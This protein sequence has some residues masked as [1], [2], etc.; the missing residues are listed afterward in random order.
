MNA[1]IDLMARLKRPPAGTASVPLPAPGLGTGIPLPPFPQP[2]PPREAAPKP[3]AQQ[4]TIKVEVGVEILAARKAASKRTA[5]Y[6]TLTALLGIGTGFAVGVAQERAARGNLAVKS[7]GDL[8][9]EVKAAN[10]KLG[11]LGEKLQEAE[12]KLGRK[13]FPAELATALGGLTIPFEPQN[14]EKP[15]IGNMGKALRSLMRYTSAVEELN[16]DR[17]R[18]RN[19]LV[20][21]QPRAEKAW[22]EENE[23]HVGFSVI[24]R[25]ERDK[26][27]MAELVPNRD[28]FRLGADFPSE[29]TVL[30]PEMAQGQRRSVE[31]KVKRWVRGDLT[32]GDPIAVPVTPQT[33]AF[34][35]DKVV[36][37]LRLGIEELLGVLRGKNMGTHLET[38]GL[39][40][41]GA[42]LADELHKLS[43]AR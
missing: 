16:E 26:G 32:G 2:V 8:E 24:F 38:N 9:R 22:K 1:R 12:G 11:E 42:D 27:M 5:L 17:E 18:L 13:E 43:L 36:P 7:A 35:A 39:I 37:Q 21:F 6:A 19:V 41:D 31:K 15:G 25:P 30:A 34:A 40:K 3:T 29:Y 10:E 20:S 23:P 28:P 33:M 4:Q 14:L